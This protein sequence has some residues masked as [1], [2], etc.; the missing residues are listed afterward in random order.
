MG[1]LGAGIRSVV[2]AAA[3]ALAGISALPT[4]AG[5]AKLEQVQ[6]VPGESPQVVLELDSSM[7]GTA[8]S[9]YVLDEPSRL[10]V[11]V[12]DASVSPSIRDLSGDGALIDKVE[13]VEAPFGDGKETKI[14][15]YLLAPV[16]HSLRT[17][18]SRVLISLSRAGGAPP[19]IAS[20]ANPDPEPVAPAITSGESGVSTVVESGS[21]TP[22]LSGTG[23][24]P[25]SGPQ[26]IRPD[27][28]LSSLDFKVLDGNRVH[29][30]VVGIK[31]SDRY[32]VTS[33][34]SNLVVVDVPGAFLPQ[35]LGR[36]LDTSEFYSPVRMV[37]AYSTSS[38]V[39]VAIS[40]RRDVEH[41]ASITEGGLIQVDFDVP[42][43]M[44]QERADAAAGAQAV[45]PSESSEGAGVFISGGGKT[46]SSDSAWGAS[47]AQDPNSLSSLGN[48]GGSSA[49]TVYSGKR[50]SLDF[51]NA[52][53]HS[54]FRLISNVSRL[55][56]VAGDDVKGTVTVRMIDVPWDQALAAILQAKGLGS[57][58][59]GNIIRVAPLETIK[60]EQA[61][62]LEAK[63]SQFEL[64]EL[65]LLVVPFNYVQA[66][67]MEEQ[68]KA[69]LSSRG[70]VEVDQTN[71]QLVIKDIEERLAQIRALVQQLD[72]KT[73]QVMIEARIVEASSNFIRALGIQWGA[74]LNASTA[75][76]R[77]TGLFFPNS[78]A[79]G[80][81]LNT[82]GSSIRPDP[83]AESLM[84]DL[85]A[86]GANSA[87]S[88]SMGS[89]PGFV[90]LDARLS[91]LE[92]DGWG[93]VVSSPKVVTLDNK[94]AKVAQGS[95]IPF[96][97]T[98]NGG[99]N[100]QFINAT[101]E[102]SVTPHITTDE[103]IFLK[104]A[105]SNNRA[106][107]SQLVAG[108]PAIQV[109]EAETELLVADGD[110]AVLGGVYATSESESH[111]YVP[112]LGRVPII[113]ALFRNTAYQM[114]RNELLVF[115][116]PRILTTKN[117]TRSGG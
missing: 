38:G 47:G 66:A 12:P 14:T 106:D 58:R 48:M 98:S 73:P 16:E 32:T 45:A 93:K 53:I 81:T 101:L 109:K 65:G 82:Q 74:S 29:R 105:M 40:L 64:Q 24:R 85:G 78:V 95:R 107:F 8:V 44:R 37:R 52:D 20:R 57:Q 39:R 117:V 70:G 30:V 54:I 114:S 75:T 46:M 77:S 104:V 102:L 86:E 3:I 33:P 42:D 92:T 10:V 69:M 25:L 23:D 21:R 116:T 97:S 89:I 62:A 96:T 35:S 79:A 22:T 67:E 61:A 34:Q 115:I 94:T 43:A 50:I 41:R 87:V 56:I 9:S 31:G 68:V 88:F 11:T 26:A 27:I 28:A 71:N 90:N 91:A 36:V 112:G 59:F 6:V 19:V 72:K 110:T 100:V 103:K 4:V 17:E 83:T 84:I 1:K 55:N 13:V 99:T 80:G 111:D 7:E 76:G 49:T 5:E 60:A 18:G 108:Q 63:R 15:L 2:V 51:V 113:G